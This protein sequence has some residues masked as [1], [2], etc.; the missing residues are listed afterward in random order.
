MESNINISTINKYFSQNK[1]KQINN[2]RTKIV[3]YSHFSVNEANIS[4]KIKQIPYY[5]NFFTILDDYEELNISQLNENIIEKLKNIDNIQYYLF[6]YSD[7]NSI[8]FIDF[9]YNFTSIKKL[10]LNIIDSFQHLLSGLHIL[11][12][13][14]IC[15]FDI[16]PKNIVFLENFREK[17]VIKNFRFS[18]NVKHLDYTY[19]SNIL[20][21][22]E[23]F[24][25]QPLEIHILYYFV[26]HDIKT[27]SYGFIEEFCENYVENLNILRLFSEN[28]KKSYKEQCIETMRKYI[29]LSKNQIIDDILERNKK[30]D[31]YGI[32]MIYLQI[33]GCI[34]RIFSLKG[35]FI[36]KITLDLSKNLHPN[37]DK[38]MSLEKTLET[39][40]KLLTE[41][42]NWSFVNKL[43]NSKLE[44]LF[45]EF[46]K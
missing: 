27:I 16:S 35:T 34:S 31:V 12:E 30:W 21:K 11:N 24:T 39:F 37:S 45:D 6:K 25:Y 29:N 46:T 13:N 9:L 22:L 4:H 10:I 43:D 23:D 19:F 15:F 44:Q 5:S 38:R 1:E 33:F 41:E 18:L 7:N 3:N 28:Y 40:N 36:S 2:Y 20:N 8:D 26:K 17:P 42:E 14:N 32:S